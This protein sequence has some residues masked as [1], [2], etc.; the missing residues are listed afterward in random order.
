MRQI[1]KNKNQKKREDA[2]S[3]NKIVFFYF[4]TEKKIA[5]LK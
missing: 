5:C 4:L 3:F 2:M 1:K